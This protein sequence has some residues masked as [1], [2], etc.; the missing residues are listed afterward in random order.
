[1]TSFEKHVI[2]GPR[3]RLVSAL[4]L[5]CCPLHLLSVPNKIITDVTCS[6]LSAWTSWGSWGECSSAQGYGLNYRERTCTGST[7]TCTGD[8]RE[9]SMC[10]GK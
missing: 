4:Q 6:Y 1:M 3:K 7:Q 8:S 5:N 10:G 9:T 2:N